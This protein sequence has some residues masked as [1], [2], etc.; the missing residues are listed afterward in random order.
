MLCMKET[1]LYAKCFT[2]L[3]CMTNIRVNTILAN[4]NVRLGPGNQCC[5]KRQRNTR[6]T[7]IWNYTHLAA[8]CWINA[9]R[10]VRRIVNRIR[11]F[12]N[13]TRDDIQLQFSVGVI[14]IQPHH[15][16]RTNLWTI[17]RLFSD[18]SA[19]RFLVIDI[20]LAFLFWCRVL[21]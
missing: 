2:S 8:E 12:W 4:K 17:I 10:A 7:L 14:N 20:Y 5:R 18:F 15:A 3:S 19:Q 21:H 1:A 6:K 9:D 11:K 13:R 16:F